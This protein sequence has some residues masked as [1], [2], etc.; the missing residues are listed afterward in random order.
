[1]SLFIATS[2]KYLYLGNDDEIET[3][4]KLSDCWNFEFDVTC[5]VI[6]NNFVAVDETSDI[7]VNDGIIRSIVSVYC[8]TITLSIKSINVNGRCNFNSLN[9]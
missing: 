4:S 7:E 6:S 2:C 9:V 8:Y 5:V 3:Q 1:M